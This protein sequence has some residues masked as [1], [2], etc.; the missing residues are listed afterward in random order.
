[1]AITDETRTPESPGVG[2]SI[3]ASHQA[4]PPTVAVSGGPK[5][6]KHRPHETKAAVLRQAAIKQQ[7]HQIRSKDNSRLPK[8][9]P[10]ESEKLDAQKKFSNMNVAR[11]SLLRNSLTYD[12]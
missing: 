9:K 5:G 3:L 11:E 4:A 12:R 2:P 6:R 8:F 10:K 1:M 7:L